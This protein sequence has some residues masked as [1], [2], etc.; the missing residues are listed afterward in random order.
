MGNSG[1]SFKEL[2]VCCRAGTMPAL[3]SLYTQHNKHQQ[4]LVGINEG[5]RINIALSWYRSRE[6]KILVLNAF[7][8][9]VLKSEL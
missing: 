2:A 3:A 4:T 7:G 8:K 1:V 5:I 6:G 9:L